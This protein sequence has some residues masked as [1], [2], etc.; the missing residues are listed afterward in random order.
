[1]MDHDNSSDAEDRWKELRNG[2][3]YYNMHNG[4][5]HQLTSALLQDYWTFLAAC[6][7]LVTS[8]R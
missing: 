5:N 1:M 8:Y 2:V 3:G 4:T 6:G 7:V